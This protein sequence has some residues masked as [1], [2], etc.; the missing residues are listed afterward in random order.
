MGTS[1]FNDICQMIELDM[2]NNTDERERSQ[3]IA[4]ICNFN[5]ELIKLCNKLEEIIYLE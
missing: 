4:E 2:Q 5:P 3:A 1:L